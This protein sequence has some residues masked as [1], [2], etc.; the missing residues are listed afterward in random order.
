MQINLCN[1]VVRELPFSEQ[2]RFAREIGYDG[3]EVA[4]FTLGEAPHLITPSQL[5][6]LRS[7]ASDEGMRISGLHWLLA[8]PV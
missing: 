6:A 1:E 5:R 2:C 3:L 7:T 8:A 4:P